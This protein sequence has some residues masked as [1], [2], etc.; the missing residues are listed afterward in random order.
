MGEVY[1]ARDPRLNREVAI[2]VL[3]TD[4]LTDENRRRRFVQEAQ[5][6]S[7][8]NH[9][10][11]VTIYEIESANGADFIVME[12]VRGKTLDGLISRQGMRLS[13]ALRIG[14]AIAD[15]LAA[16]HA[17]GIIHRDLKPANVM[18]GA[19]GAVKVLD[20][21]LAKLISADCDSDA[22]G[23]LTH[24]A[25]LA[26]SAAGTIAGTA[27]YMAPEQAIGGAVDARSDIFSFGAMLYEMVT[28]QRA[29]AGTS[30]AD[31][32]SAV[33][34]T[35]PKAPSTL[36]SD[37]PADLEKMIVRCLRKD[38]A[39]RF[40][41]VD[42]VKIALQDI[43]EESE[44]GAGP[45]VPG[46][47][48][49]RARLIAVLAVPIIL[50]VAALAWLLPVRK[51]K[52]LPP[53]RVVPLTTLTGS[54]RDP[55]FSPDGEQVAFAWNGVKQDNF[56]IYVALV[57][58]SDVRRLTSDPLPD[59][60]PVW[61]S[62]GRQIA[63]LRHRPD[64]TTIQLVSPLGGVDRRMSDFR[65]ADSIAWSPDG[66]WLAA[67][68]SGGLDLLEPN[69]PSTE[70]IDG[71]PRG[72]YLIP[73]EGGDTRQVIV[74][75]PL[76]GDSKPAFSPVG[77]RLAYRSC[78][79]TRTVA[80]PGG[81]D[82]YVIEL[83]TAHTPTGPPQRLTTQKSLTVNSLTWTRDGSAVVY[84][85]AMTDAPRY[86]WRVSVDG[87]RPPERVEI[88]GAG[89]GEPAM[90]LSGDRLAFT[91][92]SR[93][94]DIY[95]F[96]VGR[97]AQLVVG[98]TFEEMEPRLSPDGRRLVFGSKRSG[99]KTAIWVA[100]ADGLNPQ[101]LTHGPGRTQGSPSWSPDG[102]RIAFDSFTDDN[103]WHI[104]MIDADGGTPHRLTT[105]AGDEIVPTW[106][107]DGRWIY[108]SGDQGAGYNIWRVA[109]TGGAPERMTH[110][111]SG[112]FACESA[113]GKT[114]LFQP[115]DAD[116]PLMAMS[117]AGRETRQLVDCVKNSAF[118]AGP[119]GVYYVP[120]D[121]TSDP[122][123]RILDLETGR[124]RR[125]GTLESVTA[126]PLG[127]SVS[128][129]GGTIVYPRLT[130]LGADLMLIENFL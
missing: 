8:L 25:N 62:D 39:R 117:L 50:I 38:P 108:F 56:D 81:C 42:D 33:I 85:A 92:S 28:G 15:A 100:D 27:A 35:Q 111:G 7:A 96:E 51:Q 69:G 59:T 105:Q 1:R 40:Q 84:G 74:S 4:R 60:S 34:R 52:E 23:N 93:D 29:F 44:S 2:K 14:I 49:R 128:P 24:T 95:R 76:A 120:C 86:L 55:T 31:T 103:H 45:A 129:D 6:A 70:R 80:L 66:Q 83:N 67:G 13:D 10:H 72:I 3:P 107:R 99:D 68:R 19:E 130:S 73:L 22:D 9:P 54:E 32:L 115:K 53:P 75:A 64:G 91:R 88:A 79:I 104:W 119:Q 36:V 97:P 48:T 77:Q 11:I 12:Y 122:P 127:L 102:R 21:G 37:V 121:P 43:K 16:A 106:S 63:F 20:F 90:A 71:Q 98:S 89:A 65:G 30:T 58:S 125:L 57:G 112:P 118:G 47:G 116:S 5:A 126:R 26:L 17:R 124:D 61:S 46:G 87:T 114:L 110:G 94:A 78:S 82:I 41:H 109:A 123:L 18:V 113:D 101:Q